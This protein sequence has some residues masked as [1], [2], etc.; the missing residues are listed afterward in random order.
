MAA[1]LLLQPTTSSHL[2]TPNFNRIFPPPYS[3]A[4]KGT[5]EHTELEKIVHH[6]IFREFPDLLEAGAY[7]RSHFRST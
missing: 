4:G 7:I 6:A 1:E 2:N 3:K 5:P